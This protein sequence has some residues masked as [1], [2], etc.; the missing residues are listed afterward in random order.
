MY[1]LFALIF[2]LGALFLICFT[3]DNYTG[4]YKLKVIGL[5]CIFVS[6]FLISTAF[7]LKENI[8]SRDRIVT[9]SETVTY[10]L[11]PFKV[12]FSMPM[13]IEVSDSETIETSEQH[14]YVKRWDANNFGFYYKTTQNGVKGFEP[15]YITFY[16]DDEVFITDIYEGTPTILKITETTGYPISKFEMFWLCSGEIKT[17]RATTTIRYEIYVPTDSIIETLTFKPQS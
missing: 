12:I 3:N 16:S 17:L 15:G 11:L 8:K 4:A 1:I 5:L 13:E 10:K 14:Y 9:E 7:N 2:A 6:C